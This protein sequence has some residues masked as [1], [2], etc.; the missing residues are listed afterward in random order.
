MLCLYYS[1]L[2]SIFFVFLI[3]II[4]KFNAGGIVIMRDDYYGTNG[5]IIK[6]PAARGPC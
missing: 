2:G 1:R 6:V 5:N 4:N 3:L